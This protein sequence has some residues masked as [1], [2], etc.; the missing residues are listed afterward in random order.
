MTR[1]S[2]VVT[3]ITIAIPT[4]N[5]QN[6]TWNDSH[7]HNHQVIGLFHTH[8]PAGQAR[9]SY[10]ISSQLVSPPDGTSWLIRPSA[11]SWSVHC[12]SR[13]S[14]GSEINLTV[15]SDFGSS[16]FFAVT[17]SVVSINQEGSDQNY[18]KRRT[19]FLVHGNWNW[20]TDTFRR[21]LPSS[22][23]ASSA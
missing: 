13:H 17:R 9:G 11:G 23:R 3:I 14:S 15:L 12:I 1:C 5:K 4:Y 18:L 2:V 10:L 19:L 22:R 6:Q 21:P 7:N 8:N 16:R 20:C